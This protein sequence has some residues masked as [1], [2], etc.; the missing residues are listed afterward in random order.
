MK[1]TSHEVWLADEPI[2]EELMPYLGS[3]T[4]QQL[5]RRGA[6]IFS[7]NRLSNPLMFLGTI[8]WTRED[9]QI[10]GERIGERLI[11]PDNSL[12]K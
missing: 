8:A 2:R 3:F 4:A 7:A 6:E 1:A 9:V 10:L 5:M 12:A 11:V